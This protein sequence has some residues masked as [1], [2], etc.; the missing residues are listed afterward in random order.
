MQTF[1]S[2]EA[3][4]TEQ[5]ETGDKLQINNTYT[6]SGTLCTPKQGAKNPDH[7]QLLVH[8]VGFDSRFVLYEASSGSDDD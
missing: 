4:F 1:I 7:V 8:G 2:S 6:L 5:Y 3:N